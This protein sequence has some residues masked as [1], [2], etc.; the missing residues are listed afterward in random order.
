MNI[1][2]KNPQ[3]AEY[4]TEIFHNMK[5][6]TEQVNIRFEN[7]GMY[8]QTMDTSHISIIDVTIPNDWFDEY[9]K[10][11]NTSITIGINTIILTKMLGTRDKTQTITLQLAGEEVDNLFLHFTGENKTIFDKHFE[12]PLLSLEQDLMVI[13][14]DYEPEAEFALSSSYFYNLINQLK[15]FSASLDITCSEENIILSSKSQEQGKMKVII[16]INEITYYSIDEGETLKLSFSLPFMYNICMYNKIS[17]EIKLKLGNN[18]PL[19]IIYHIGG[20]ETAIMRFFLAP[21]IADDDDN[22][23][24]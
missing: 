20:S 5:L 15:L 16:D 19:Q 9:I 4:F 22:D 2:I 11:S 13:P 3:N 6:F 14:N 17:K 1:S 7:D 8:I 18:Y 24:N 21:K 23:D 10:E 12:I